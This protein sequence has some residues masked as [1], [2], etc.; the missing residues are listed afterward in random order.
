MSSKLQASCKTA[1]IVAL[2]GVYHSYLP[3]QTHFRYRDPSP[4]ACGWDFH[5]RASAFSS[6]AMYL[7]A[8]ARK[9]S[10]LGGG[11]A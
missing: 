5:F 9:L 6:M 11:S 3:G 4:A 8:R 10:I 2:R 7:A 1:S